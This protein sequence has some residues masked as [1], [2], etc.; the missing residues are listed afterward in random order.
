MEQPTNAKKLNRSRKRLP[1]A[2]RISEAKQY[3]RKKAD[4][5][6]CGESCSSTLVDDCDERASQ[7]DSEATLSDD[8]PAIYAKR[9]TVADSFR[10]NPWGQAVPDLVLLKIFRYVVDSAGAIPFLPRYV[11]VL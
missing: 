7:T 4:V 6:V 3:K 9:D 1:K 11:C 5:A 2:K 10:Y 8:L